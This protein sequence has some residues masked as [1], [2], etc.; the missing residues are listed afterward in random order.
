MSAFP[1][2]MLL[3]S[4]AFGGGALVLR[5]T[6]TLSAF[7]YSESLAISFCLGVGVIGWCCF[8]LALA[9]LINSVGIALSLGFLSCGIYF[10]KPTESW[11]W[12]F[13]K[14]E[15]LRLALLVIV[16]LVLGSDLL[17][18]LAPPADGDS[19]AYHF[20][21]PK[22]I[23]NFGVL[24]PVFRAVEGT[25]P[26]LQQMTYLAALGIGGEQAMTLWTMASGWGATA[27]LYVIARRYIGINWSLVVA[28]VFL[29]TPAVLYGAG[30][31][32][33]E[34]R[35]A[36]FVL[37]AV[38]AVSEARRTNLFRY[39]ILA[40]VAAGLFVASKYTGLIF[41]FSAGVLLLFQKRW[42]GHCLAFSMTLIIVG[43]QW[44]GWNTWITG[45]PIFP[46][47]YGKIEYL[48]AVPWNEAINVV[49]ENAMKEKVVAANLFWLFLYPVYATISPD[50]LFESLRV[51]FGPLVLLIL[52]FSVM[53]VWVFRRQLNRHP[54]LIF[55][56]CPGRAA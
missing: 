36:S 43:G 37:I 14:P 4:A 47:L 15:P 28:L 52:P 7:R 54:L 48:K 38:L 13:S 16:T 20:A 18:G 19:L 33:I 46:V 1:S 9:G 23:L 30:S 42:F 49:Y 8:F 41:A 2:L 50:P 35:N 34:V 44:Y 26:L 51:G 40:G 24:L 22:S 31:G 17:E 32:Q 12:N 27:I 55:G 45:D 5:G 29:T 21:L 53:G 25:I 56:N 10:L 3:I 11:C 6:G 39:A